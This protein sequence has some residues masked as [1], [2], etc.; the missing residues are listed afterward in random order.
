[1]DTAARTVTH[2]T[3]VGT[4]APS[5]RFPQRDHGLNPG[6]QDTEAVQAA[7]WFR[8]YSEFNIIKTY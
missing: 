8:F 7:V 5:L 6:T 1:M 3:P 4:E 2:I